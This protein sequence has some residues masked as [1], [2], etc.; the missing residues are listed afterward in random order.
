MN[1]IVTGGC[2]FIGSHLVKQ[3]LNDGHY[4]TVIDNLST[5]KKSY[6]PKSDKLQ[7]L[8]VDITNWGKLWSL[9]NNLGIKRADG[10]FHVAAF[11]RIQPSLKDPTLTNNINVNGTLNILELMRLIDIDNIVY[12]ASSSSYGLKNKLP[13]VETQSPDCLTPYAHSK[14][15]AELM[16]KTWGTSYAIQNACVKYFNVYGERSPEQ[17]AYAPV[18]GLFFRQALLDK[19]DLTV[20]GDGEQRRDFTYVSDVVEANIAAMDTLR[21]HPQEVS[22]LT[23]NVGC[24]KNY[25]INE[26]ADMVLKSLQKDGLALNIKVTH[27][28]PRVGESRETLASVKL[29]KKLLNWKPTVSLEEGVERLKPYYIEKFAG[30]RS[31]GRK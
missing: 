1:Y 8:E 6:L 25:T 22:G 23:F 14:Y 18:I 12:S 9:R 19:T 28:P 24:G 20:V 7:F 15:A 5:G 3:L 29:A 10:V 2:G 26:L 27:V 21:L 13:N 4:V 31:R 11:A 16:C 17:G 30:T